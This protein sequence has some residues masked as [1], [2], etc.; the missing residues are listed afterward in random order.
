[1]KAIKKIRTIIQTILLSVIF[2][3]TIISCN[4]APPINKPKE[5]TAKL[6]RN[7]IFKL[8]D[9]L[10]TVA[11]F[12]K[13]NLFLQKFLTENDSLSVEDSLKIFNRIAMNFRKKG[14]YDG[15]FYYIRKAI[16]IGEKKYKNSVELSNSYY[17]IGLFFKDYTETDSSMKYLRKA[18]TIRKHIFRK[19]NPLMGDVYNNM[20]VIFWLRS[21]YRQAEKYFRL[22]L[23]LRKQRGRFDKSVGGTYVNLANLYRELKKFKQALAY[24]DSTLTVRK[25]IYG[26]K[27]PQIAY[28][29]I[30][31]GALLADMGMVDSSI[32][33]N[34]KALKILKEF[35]PEGHPNIAVIYNNLGLKYLYIGD[36]RNAEQYFLSSIRIKRKLHAMLNINFANNYSNLGETYFYLKDY[37]KAI[38]YY[39]LSSSLYKKISGENSFDY[40]NDLLQLSKIY[41][42]IGDTNRGLELTEKCVKLLKKSKNISVPDK[43]KLFL[44]I[45][46]NYFETNKLHKALKYFRKS[47]AFYNKFNLF[48][49]AYLAENY[50]FISKILLKLND[51]R[52]AFNEC[53]TGISVLLS[54]DGKEVNNYAIENLTP[55]DKRLLIKLLTLRGD[56]YRKKFANTK[57][58]V[59]L[60]NAVSDF[61]QAIKLSGNLRRNYVFEKSKLEFREELKGLFDEAVQTAFE[62]FSVTGSEKDFETG[63]NLCEKSKAAMLREKLDED[64]LKK[65]AGIPDSLIKLEKSLLRKIRYFSR[66][67]EN[68]S[69]ND[70]SKFET[71]RSHLF[72]ARIKLAEIRKTFY[73]KYP[74][75][76]EL[77]ETPAHLTIKDIREGVLGKNQTTLVYYLDENNIYSFII[78]PTHI[79]LIKTKRPQSLEKKVEQLRN[80]IKKSDLSEFVKN[81]YSIYKTIFEPAEDFITTKRCLIV[82]DG[83]INFIPFDALIESKI[84]SKGDFKNLPYLVK[85][86]AF[87]YSFSLNVLIKSCKIETSRSFLGIAPGV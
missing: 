83:I 76:K 11:E 6:L 45:G 21:D 19:D 34:K 64:K 82:P 60:Q 28:A 15:A 85:K 7:K 87:S 5:P 16:F 3:L 40:I 29:L 79:E 41:C 12:D 42:T 27:H 86:Y 8:A 25:K 69:E 70:S 78:S 50:Y 63:L 56:I 31:K 75:Y 20:G 10:S 1:M 67:Y 77:L 39:K 47:I 32:V 44:M 72:E 55:I 57:N 48:V 52:G 2:G 68:I 30:N 35:F 24:Y 23:K 74:S 71:Y 81:S 58:I 73:N 38:H 13:S 53:D 22:A 61:R 80:S 59:F 51:I 84:I 66:L 54:K 43:A 9:S 62:I 26:E 36:F 33:Y 49:K 4:N 46:N 18:L 65:A 37:D 14:N 17:N